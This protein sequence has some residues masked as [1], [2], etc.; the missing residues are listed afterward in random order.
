MGLLGHIVFSKLI[1]PV[2]IYFSKKVKIQE[3]KR[4]KISKS[5]FPTV[6]AANILVF[7]L[8]AV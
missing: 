7:F 8:S 3:N 5:S 1:F 6:N 2:C 4:E